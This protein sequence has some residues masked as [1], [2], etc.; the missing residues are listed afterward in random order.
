MGCL[1]GQ[2]RKSG[3][4][5]FCASQAFRARFRDD[6]SRFVRFPAPTALTGPELAR[7]GTGAAGPTWAPGLA[8]PA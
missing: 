4:P 6:G 7:V 2:A 8:P 5:E 3:P 1:G